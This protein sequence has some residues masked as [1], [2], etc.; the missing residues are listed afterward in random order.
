[1]LNEYTLH[2]SPVQSFFVL[3]L[4]NNPSTSSMNQKAQDEQYY[5]YGSAKMNR[6]VDVHGISFNA[7][8]PF[9]EVYSLLIKCSSFNFLVLVGSCQVSRDL[10]F[11]CEQTVI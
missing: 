9:S 4:Y 7:S 6:E 10:C 11:C 3:G 1:M 5:T 8:T 2:S